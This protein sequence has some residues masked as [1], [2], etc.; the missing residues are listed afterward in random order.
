MD[1]SIV[2]SQYESLHLD[3]EIDMNPVQVDSLLEIDSIFHFPS[4]IK[5]KNWII[6]FLKNKTCEYYQ[7]SEYSKKLFS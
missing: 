5:G 1:F 4:Y 7:K 2:Q 3:V 6:N